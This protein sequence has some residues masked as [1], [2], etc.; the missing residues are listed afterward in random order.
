MATG[1]ERRGLVGGRSLLRTWEGGE[2]GFANTNA[3]TALRH[4]GRGGHFTFNGGPAMSEGVT[5]TR[6][7][8]GRTKE[9]QRKNEGEDRG[10]NAFAK[11]REWGR[12]R[13]ERLQRGFA[14]GVGSAGHSPIDAQLPTTHGR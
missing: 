9:G 1:T 4:A 7:R 11:A 2:E 3:D 14:E 5:P 8:G 12:W 6:E 10:A 13:R